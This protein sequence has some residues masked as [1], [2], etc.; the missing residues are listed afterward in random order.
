MKKV[1]F[2][3]FLQLLLISHSFAQKYTRDFSDQA[4]YSEEKEGADQ[5]F[6]FRDY[7]TEKIK[8]ELESI[9][10]S[11]INNH[12]LGKAVARRLQLIEDCYTYHSKAPGA[13]S[14][15]KVIQKPVIYKSIYD[16]EKHYKKQVRKNGQ[17]IAAAAAELCEYLNLA[18]IL[19]YNDTEKFETHLRNSDSEQDMID[20][21]NKVIIK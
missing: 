10:E 18:L 11:A 8:K 3:L 19:L 5:Y 7:S 2:I 20:I 16:I 9:D 17:E 1:N 15:R 6:V 14:S 4:P 13:I 21:F 12:L